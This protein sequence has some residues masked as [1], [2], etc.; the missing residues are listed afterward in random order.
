MSLRLGP[1]INIQT[2]SILLQKSFLVRMDRKRIRQ[3]VWLLIS[4]SAL[5]TIISLGFYI[6]Y[7]FK[8]LVFAQLAVNSGK[9]VAQSEKTQSL[10]FAWI[11]FATELLCL[12]E[13]C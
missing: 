7:R 6:A 1:D 4:P 13:F 2:T 9:P 8:C 5:C 11:F 3:V 12:G 10:V